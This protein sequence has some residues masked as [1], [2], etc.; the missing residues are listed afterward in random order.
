MIKKVYNYS[1][2]EEDA[3]T[4]TLGDL[5]PL[6]GSSRIT[7]QWVKLIVSHPSKDGSDIGSTKVY[8]GD[9]AEE[10]FIESIN[11]F[12]NCPVR[13]VTSETENGKSFIRVIVHCDKYVPFDLNEHINEFA[14]DFLTNYN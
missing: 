1:S 5:L 10:S 3:V 11:K 12:M 6:L 13:N 4:V 9:V 2:G 14:D 7:H 8:E